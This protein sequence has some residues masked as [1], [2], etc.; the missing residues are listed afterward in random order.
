M[1]IKQPP[2]KSTGGKI[3][4]PMI[5]FGPGILEWNVQR[6]IILILERM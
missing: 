2:R 4:R 1:R 6:G 3:P 5:C